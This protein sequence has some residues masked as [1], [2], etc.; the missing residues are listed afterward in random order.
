MKIN[1]GF[2]LILFGIL[3]AVIA[4]LKGFS[5]ILAY[6]VVGVGMSQLNKTW[7]IKKKK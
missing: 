7:E 3:Y 4:N 6:L 1:R 2:V 5:D